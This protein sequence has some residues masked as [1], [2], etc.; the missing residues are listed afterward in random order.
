M[1]E[2]PRIQVINTDMEVHLHVKEGNHVHVTKFSVAEALTLATTIFNVV[3]ERER[4]KPKEK[5]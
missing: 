3:K 5:A 2:T 1:S 4:K